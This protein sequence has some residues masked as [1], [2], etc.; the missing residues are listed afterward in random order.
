MK[1]EDLRVAIW[2]LKILSKVKRN[3][4]ETHRKSWKTVNKIVQA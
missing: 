1:A 3:S 2:L 4:F